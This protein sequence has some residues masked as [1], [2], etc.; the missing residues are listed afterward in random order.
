MRSAK[1]TQTESVNQLVEETFKAASANHNGR[2]I[3]R[4]ERLTNIQNGMQN[5]KEWPFEIYSLA[6]FSV[7]LATALAQI[8]IALVN[9]KVIHVP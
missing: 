3:E 6:P 1:I 9:L 2:I 4:L 7:A 5:Q 8:I